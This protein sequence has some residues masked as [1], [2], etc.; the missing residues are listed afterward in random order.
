MS[1]GDLETKMETALANLWETLARV[2]STVVSKAVLDLEVERK[3]GNGKVA[4][5]GSLVLKAAT[6]TVRA[7]KECGLLPPNRTIEVAGIQKSVWNDVF[8]QTDF[9]T[10]GQA[11]STPQNSMSTS[12]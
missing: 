5:Q 2:I 9:P 3:K 7:I 6:H 8:P 1:R 10:S 11:G 4:N 12:A